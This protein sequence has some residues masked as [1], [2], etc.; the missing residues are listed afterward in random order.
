MPKNMKDAWGI[1]VFGLIETGIGLVALVALT[2]SFLLGTSTK[3]PAVAIFVL[4]ASIVSISLGIGIMRRN[5]FC[6]RSLLYFSALVILSKILIAGNIITLS[7]ALET[8]MPPVIKNIISVLY[9]GALILYLIR[10]Q[11]KKEFK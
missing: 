3:P 1:Q 6:Y 7:G 8:A 2:V 11:I 4:T 9:H 5:L 10:P